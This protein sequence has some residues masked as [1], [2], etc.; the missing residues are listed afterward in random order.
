MVVDRL[1][2]EARAVAGLIP[3]LD[4]RPNVR[5][6]VLPTGRRRC[7]VEPDVV[8][9]IGSGRNIFQ[10]AFCFVE[11][12]ASTVHE[13]LQA[14]ALAVPSHVP[15]TCR[16][17]R[18]LEAMVHRSSEIH[19]TVAEFL[20]VMKVAAVYP[21]ESIAYLGSFQSV[22][23]NPIGELATDDTVVK[24]Q[25]L[26]P[27]RLLLGFGLELYLFQRLPRSILVAILQWPEST[28]VSR[29]EA[30]ALAGLHVADPV[31]AHLAEGFDREAPSPGVH[32]VVI[33]GEDPVRDVA[34]FC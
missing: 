3:S 25:V 14:A 24:Q 23:T 33:P 15:E 19:S 12:R 16:T 28:P 29:A 32:S 9:Q 13:V 6:D 20:G 31:V 4:T 8:A 7:H 1:V 11:P 26:L 2:L 18:I 34:R 17:P 27:P 22:V 5:L 21:I 30:V 10:N